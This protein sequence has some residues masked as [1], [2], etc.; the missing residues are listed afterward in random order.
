MAVKTIT[1]FTAVT[2]GNLTGAAVMLVDD[3][4]ANTRKATL[5]TLRTKMFAGS[6]GY[7]ASDPLVVGTINCSSVVATGNIDLATGTGL[8]GSGVTLLKSNGGNLQLLDGSNLVKFGTM[9]IT[10]AQVGNICVTSS[11]APSGNPTGGG[12][13]WYEAGVGFRA[14][15]AGGTVTTFA[16]A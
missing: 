3:S 9:A 6:T 8:T 13:I 15:G 10:N 1:N 12:F 7:T 14:R 5:A 11:S 16:A 4:N 2:A